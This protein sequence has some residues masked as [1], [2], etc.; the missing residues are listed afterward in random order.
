MEQVIQTQHLDMIH[1]AQVDYYGKL[2]ATASSDRTIKIFDLSTPQPT[3]INDITGHEGPVWQ[4][5][6]NSLFRLLGIG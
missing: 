4:V 6:C 1:D 2:L 5:Y 3:H